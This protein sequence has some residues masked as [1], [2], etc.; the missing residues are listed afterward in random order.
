MI[1]VG[2]MSSV[3]NM[4]NNRANNQA[5]QN[6]LQ[7]NV[8]QT[9]RQLAKTSVLQQTEME[10]NQDYLDK[11]KNP[12]ATP[13]NQ[14]YKNLAD[15]SEDEKISYGVGCQMNL[16]ESFVDV[17]QR[18]AD[19]ADLEAHYEQLVMEGT[20]DTDLQAI[21]ERALAFYRE[22]GSEQSMKEFMQLSQTFDFSK[23]YDYSTNGNVSK[24]TN[25]ILSDLSSLGFLG[26][27]HLDS[28][29]A[30]ERKDALVNAIGIVQERITETGWTT[31]KG[32]QAASKGQLS[33]LDS[34]HRYSYATT[35]QVVDDFSKVSQ[36]VK[37][38]I[39]EILN[40]GTGTGRPA[41]LPKADGENMPYYEYMKKLTGVSVTGAF[42][43]RA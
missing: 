4:L 16:A 41:V 20:D 1:P 22:M 13:S 27:S 25:Y 6:L 17:L 29:T 15:M 11:S 18:C 19:Y 30:S 3:V 43:A 40:S 34:M 9:L 12:A 8:R 35:V 42:N 24:E 36:I 7:N 37:S 21:N 33:E 2:K 5:S 31:D 10:Y 14:P 39:S 23:M 28:M 26:L 32:Y 38:E